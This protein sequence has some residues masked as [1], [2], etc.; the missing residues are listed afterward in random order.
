M[1]RRHPFSPGTTGRDTT[2]LSDTS[3]DEGQPRRSR[4]SNLAMAK[5][6]VHVANPSPSEV[7]HDLM[8]LSDP[9]PMT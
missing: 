3:G 6:V 1:G 2:T 4:G 9:F 8:A 5:V 7:H